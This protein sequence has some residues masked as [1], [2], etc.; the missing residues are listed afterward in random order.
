[1]TARR[2]TMTG[3]EARRWRMGLGL[4]VT[5]AGDALNLN[6][7]SVTFR[8]YERAGEPGGRSPSPPTVALMDLTASM[9][10]ALIHLGAGSPA[11]AAAVLITSLPTPILK[12]IQGI[13][14]PVSVDNEKAAGH[15][16][17]AAPST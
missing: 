11:E 7:P 16:V 10:M 17:P 8:E 2:K 3:A 13:A 1:M 14:G 15:G 5:E 4:S 9:A 6:N 12:R